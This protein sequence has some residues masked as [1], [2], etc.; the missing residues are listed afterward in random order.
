MSDLRRRHVLL[1]G[2]TP[3][4]APLRAQ[5]GRW[6][7]GQTS[8]VTGPV[9]SGV[10]E[11]IVGATLYFDSVNAEGGVSGR[12]VEL[13]TLDDH[14]EPKL[15]AENARKLITDHDAISLFMSRGTPHTEAIRPLLHQFE[16]P[17][18]APST[19]AMVLHQ[20]VDPWIFNVR[21]TYQREAEKAVA[22]L[23]TVGMTRIGIAR[24]DDSFGADGSEGALRGFAKAQRKPVFEVRFARTQ[25][26]LQE[27]VQQAL[28]HDAQAVIVI[29]S[30]TVV[31]KGTQ[32]LR[33]AGS[34]AQIVTLS[35]NASGGFVK[36]MGKYA[37]GT[38]VTQVFPYE[39][40]MTTAFVRQAHELAQAAKVAELTPQML[41]GFAGAKVMV[42]GLKRAGANATRTSL[43]A[44]L[45][46]LRRF[47][48]GGLEVNYSPTDHSGLDFADLSI[49]G[50]E[51]HFRR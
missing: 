24:V 3:W 32:A 16:I 33:E 13:L 2:L 23:T 43:Q 1:L 21:A 42:E 41:E 26:D 35:N 14:F 30:A 36:Q 12:K 5:P 8:G 49:I 46:S 11:N 9:A 18:V 40:S 34:L 37:S 39:R 4:A 22:H 6:L 19:G 50:E 15:A 10:H 25:P 28:A 47:D 27:L 17:M 38:I 29:A 48:I 51:G 7:I 20:P 45:N 44:A 31:S